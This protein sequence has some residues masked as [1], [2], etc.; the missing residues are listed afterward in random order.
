MDWTNQSPDFGGFEDRLHKSF[1]HSKSLGTAG[2]YLEL[3]NKG[4]CG[5]VHK[6]NASNNARPTEAIQIITFFCLFGYYW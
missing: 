5:N 1:I 2:N 4:D 3:S 6:N